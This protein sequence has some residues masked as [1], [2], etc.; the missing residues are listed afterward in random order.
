MC[1]CEIITSPVGFEYW[2][3]GLICHG[4][5]LPEDADCL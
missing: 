1:Y 4:K 3:Y 5:Y 2:E